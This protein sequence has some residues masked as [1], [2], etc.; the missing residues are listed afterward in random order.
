VML[1]KSFP[2]T[3]PHIL[4]DNAAKLSRAH[5]YHDQGIFDALV[6]CPAMAPGP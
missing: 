5:C 2:V 6:R 3:L 4:K 1:I